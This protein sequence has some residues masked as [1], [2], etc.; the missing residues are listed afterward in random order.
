MCIK[1]VLTLKQ[2]FVLELKFCEPLVQK[3]KQTKQSDQ[4]ILLLFC[5]VLILKSKI[6]NLALGKMLN[7]D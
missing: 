3:N 1:F 7:L 5:S 2:N 4:Q 6:E